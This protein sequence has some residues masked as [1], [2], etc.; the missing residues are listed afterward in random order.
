M[1]NE[2]IEDFKLLN[3][4]YIL[5]NELKEFPL[6]KIKKKFAFLVYLSQKNKF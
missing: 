6:L 1:S 5:I 2:E 4:N 3:C